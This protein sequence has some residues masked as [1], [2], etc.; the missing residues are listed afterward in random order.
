MATQ[1]A[2]PHTVFLASSYGLLCFG[3]VFF[4]SLFLVGQVDWLSCW[5]ICS[6]L[7]TC[8]SVH[9]FLKFI[10]FHRYFDWS[11]RILDRRTCNI[12][13]WEILKPM[14]FWRFFYS[15]IIQIATVL[16]EPQWKFSQS[17]KF[18]N[19]PLNY[20]FSGNS[21]TVAVPTVVHSFVASTMH[22]TLPTSFDISYLWVFFSIFRFLDIF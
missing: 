9:F 22:I 20:S 12:I 7:N 17:P 13:Y 8:L 5:E 21:T 18:W 4:L 1:I 10:T 2:L 15:F 11:S 3:L 14:I 6:I 19:Q 16:N